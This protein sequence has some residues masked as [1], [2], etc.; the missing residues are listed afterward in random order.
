MNEKNELIWDLVGALREIRSILR[1]P[2]GIGANLALQEWFR[3]SSDLIY[4]AEDLLD[5]E[6]GSI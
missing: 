5:R 1:Q 2:A 3:D 6:A 4:E